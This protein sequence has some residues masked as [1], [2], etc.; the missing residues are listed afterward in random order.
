MEEKISYWRS[1]DF[2][3]VWVE[4][5]GIEGCVICMDP[6][7]KLSLDR[8]PPVQRH[9]PP[10]RKKAESAKQAAVKS[11][12]ADIEWVLTGVGKILEARR[13]FDRWLDTPRPPNAPG[14]TKVSA[15]EL[16]NAVTKVPAFDIQEIPGVV[17]RLGML[18]AAA[19]FDRWFAG[20]LNYSPTRQDEI[21]GVNQYGLQY[22]PAMVDKTS[23]S[24]D[25]ILK[26]ER[27]KSQLALLLNELVYSADAKKE[28]AKILINYKHK[29]ILL[30]DV[31]C[32]GDIQLLHRDFQFQRSEVD[33]SL[34]QKLEQYLLRETTRRGMPDE[35]SMI[36]RA[37]SIYVAIGYVSLT[38]V[39]TK[40]VAAVSHVWVYV[41]DSFSFT[42]KSGERSQ[43]LGLWNKSGVGIVPAQVLAAKLSKP[44]WVDHPVFENAFLGN[45]R[46]LYPVKNSDFRSWQQKN[47]QGGDFIIYSNKISMRLNRPITIEL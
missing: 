38:A 8:K 36:F 31:Q 3:R 19:I 46:V 1:S 44:F 22:P 7:V 30:P 12:V 6:E 20:A 24:L 43:Y 42:D 15:K 39:G 40:T 18:K 37:F 28:L 33:T 25:W 13:K 21:N 16:L 34:M 5:K 32:H 26:F 17:R 4:K 41:K 45:F 10:E 11:D 29:A 9:P 14:V 47:Q 27:A 2:W 35:L 23:I